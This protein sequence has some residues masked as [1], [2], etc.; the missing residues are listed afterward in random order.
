MCASNESAALSTAAI[1]PCAYFVFDSSR[2]ALGDE[3]DVPV[4]GRLEGEGQ[5]GDAASDDQKVRRERHRRDISPEN[6]VLR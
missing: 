6:G 5:P 2:A 1:P 3:D 4:G